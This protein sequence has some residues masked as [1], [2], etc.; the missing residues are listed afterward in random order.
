MNRIW[1]FLNLLCVSFIYFHSN[2]SASG[3]MMGSCIDLVVF[4]E[5]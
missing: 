1:T 3:L 2:S 4:G 5:L